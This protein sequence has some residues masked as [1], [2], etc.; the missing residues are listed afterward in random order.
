M[1]MLSEKDSVLISRLLDRDERALKGFYVLHKQS[2][3]A[4]IQKTIAESEE[5]EEILQDTF[6]DFIE[7]LRDFRGQSSLKTYLYSIAKNKIIDKLRRKKIRKIFFSHIPSFIIDSFATVLFDDQLDKDYILKKIT[8]VLANLPHDYERVL[9]LKYID[10]RSVKEIAEHTH[11]PFKTTESLLFR[12][13][14]AF[15]NSYEQYD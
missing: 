11:L 13:R 5:S 2:L 8:A 4:F 6:L 3:L 10:G 7:G 1:A 9:R 12:A 14:K 15:I